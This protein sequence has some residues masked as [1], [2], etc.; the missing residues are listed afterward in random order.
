MV[1]KCPSQTSGPWSGL[2]GLEGLVGRG[3]GGGA[4][5]FDPMIRERSE[6]CL[7]CRTATKKLNLFLIMLRTSFCFATYCSI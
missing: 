1:S 3:G 4:P 5:D 7:I 2:S 6:T